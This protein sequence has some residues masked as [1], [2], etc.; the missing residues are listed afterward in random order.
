M[1]SGGGQTENVVSSFVLPSTIGRYELISAEGRRRACFSCPL[2]LFT[3]VEHASPALLIT[4]HELSFYSPEG[5]HAAFVLPPVAFRELKK[6]PPSLR[7]TAADLEEI[8][9]YGEESE[10]GENSS[11]SFGDRWEPDVSD[12]SKMCE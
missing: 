8:M 2:R 6:P 3:D 1:L 11:G 9:A 10:Q 12:A 7:D 4:R 5:H